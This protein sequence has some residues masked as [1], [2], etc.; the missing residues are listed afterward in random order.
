M[1]HSW[2]RPF[3]AC[4]ACSMAWLFMACTNPVQSSAEWVGRTGS[5]LQQTWGQPSETT[6]NHAAR[7][8]RTLTYISYWQGGF[9]VPRTCRHTFETDANDVIVSHMASACSS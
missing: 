4:S 3:L 9:G 7:G 2:A 6:P 1:F 8:G 5:G